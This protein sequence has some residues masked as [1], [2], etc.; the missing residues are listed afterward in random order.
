M[1]WCSE[2]IKWDMHPQS[3]LSSVNWDYMFLID[4]CHPID[5]KKLSWSMESWGI[6]WSISATK[7]WCWTGVAEGIR[8]ARGGMSSFKLQRSCRL[9]HKSTNP[10]IHQPSP[11]LVSALN[12]ADLCVLLRDHMHYTT[13]QEPCPSYLHNVKVCGPY[14]VTLVDWTP[15]F[16]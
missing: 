13:N 14:L 1:N 16:E 6:R 10:P 12:S 2:M 7:I 11:S 9:M 3:F 15:I 8:L 4:Q 5:T